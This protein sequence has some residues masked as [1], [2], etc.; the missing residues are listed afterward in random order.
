MMKVE[1]NP[2]VISS[3]TTLTANIEKAFHRNSAQKVFCA[4]Y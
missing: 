3:Q 2:L 1:H 4:F